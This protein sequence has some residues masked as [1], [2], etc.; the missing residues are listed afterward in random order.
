MSR[1]RNLGKKGAAPPEKRPKVVIEAWGSDPNLWQ[2]GPMSKSATTRWKELGYTVNCRTINATSVD[3]AIDQDRLSIIRTQL[4]TRGKWEWDHLD[5]ELTVMRPLIQAIFEPLD[6][7]NVWDYLG[8]SD[9]GSHPWIYRDWNQNW[10][11]AL[12]F[13]QFTVWC[14]PPELAQPLLTFL[15]NS[16][17]ECPYS[18]VVLLF[19]P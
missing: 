14:P 7:A 9:L 1:R 16:W 18:S 19:I 2:Y 8:S 11:A 15:L 4:D 3:G 12:C 6:P 5:Q 17:V 10:T 13:H